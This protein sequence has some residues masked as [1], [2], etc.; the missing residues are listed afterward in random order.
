MPELKEKIAY[1]RGLAEGLELDPNS[2]EGKLW[3]ALFEVLEEV[4]SE[5]EDLAVNQDDLEEYIEVLDEDLGEI[6]DDFY[7]DDENY[8]C[9]CCEDEVVDDYLG[10]SYIEVECP[11]CR[12]IVRFDAEIL[13]DDDVIEVYC[14]NCDEVVYVNDDS[15]LFGEEDEDEDFSEDDEE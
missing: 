6:E 5:I 3:A 11:S 7:G 8:Y 13:D 15:F 2:K 9:D 1:L 10:G 12:D 14:P 4:S